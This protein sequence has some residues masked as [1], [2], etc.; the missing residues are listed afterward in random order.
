MNLARLAI[1]WAADNAWLRAHLP[2]FGFVRRSVARFMPGERLDDALGAAESLA[3]DGVPAT[4]T[5]LGENVTTA[6]EAD[7][8]AAHYL[9][10]F[11]RVAERGLDVEISVKPTHLGLDVDPRLAARNLA[12]LA[13]RAG[14]RRNWLWVD[15]EA[16]AYVEPT[17]ELY[18]ELRSRHANTGICLQAYLRRTAD[19]VEYLLPLDPS[20]RL[21]KGAYREPVELLVGSRSLIDESFRVLSL[22]LLE[23]RGPVGR[24][25]LGTHDVD[26]VARIERDATI[27]GLGREALEIA[28]LY[29]IRTADQLR[30]AREG[31]AIRTLIAYG[32]YWYPW[33]MRRIAEKPIENTLLALRNLLG[34]G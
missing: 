21:V 9:D 23:G 20:I 27:R 18:R 6:A 26:L 16:S 25:V 1:L 34:D 8:V 15:M 29:G 17:V 7:R 5:A 4:F 31:A 10:A 24:V 33:F 13:E 14:E 12:R 11:D 19:D 30:F 28:M 22:R 32:T 2:R 3:S